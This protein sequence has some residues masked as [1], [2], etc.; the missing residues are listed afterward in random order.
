M[1]SN[2]ATTIALAMTA[3]LTGS[4]CSGSGSAGPSDAPSTSQAIKCEGGNACAA[5]SECAT[6]DGKSLCSGENEC[7]GTGYV[8]TETQEQCTA[9]QI[10]NKP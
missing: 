10:R 4:A 7:K 9:L 8:Y 5:L 6:A 1:D 3:L 2:K